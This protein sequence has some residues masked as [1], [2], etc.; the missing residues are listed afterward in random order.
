MA[1]RGNRHHSFMVK[2]TASRGGRPALAVFYNSAEA[3]CCALTRQAPPC[4]R[5]TALHS[6]YPPLLTNRIFLP[7][8]A[9][10]A[11]SRKNRG[12]EEAVFIARRRGQAQG[13]YAQNRWLIWS[14]PGQNPRA[15]PAVQS[16]CAACGIIPRFW[17][18]RPQKVFW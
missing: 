13:P 2:A 6:Y 4:P 16:R 15:D 1:I 9:A 8:R 12:R 5:A 11:F 17:R 3:V 10:R 14:G 7:N 18:G